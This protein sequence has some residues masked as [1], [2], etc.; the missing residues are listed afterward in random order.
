MANYEEFFIDLLNE[1]CPAFNGFFEWTTVID[2]LLRVA[3]G[4][5]RYC[6]LNDGDFFYALYT[7][8]LPPD[9]A[10]ELIQKAARRLDQHLSS[11]IPE[12][13]HYDNYT[14]AKMNRNVLCLL[15]SSQRV[16]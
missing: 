12:K 8:G 2:E 13:L 15:E 14:V 4:Y 1:Y 7:G 9:V 3:L 11:F 6:D 16:R 5:E 10:K